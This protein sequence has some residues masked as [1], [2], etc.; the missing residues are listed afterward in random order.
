MVDR[1]DR[2]HLFLRI[3]EQADAAVQIGA[4]HHQPLRA[5]RQG[6]D[7]VDVELRRL[8]EPIGRI[9]RIA[10]LHLAR[11]DRPLGEQPGDDVHQ[12]R[13]HLERFA[14]K[15]DADQR[16]ERLTLAAPGGVEIGARLVG[17]QHR[18][19]IERVDQ[20]IVEA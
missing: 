8:A 4:G 19:G 14:R 5:H 3:V 20:T 6:M 18:L 9:E 7:E 16:I 2:P 17:E 1:A 11:V 13:R 10:R 12:P 15:A